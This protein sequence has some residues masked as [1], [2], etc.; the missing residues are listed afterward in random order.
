MH[1]G[2]FAGI[3]AVEDQVSEASTYSASRGL[4][5]NAV[6]CC[7]RI[8]APRESSA[9]RAAGR[10]ECSQERKSRHTRALYAGHEAQREQCADFHAGKRRIAA[11]GA[12]TTFLA[13]AGTDQD[14]AQHGAANQRG[15]A[16]PRKTTSL[17]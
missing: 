12:R 1:S 3:R 5:A 6:A 14:H 9:D 10:A 16:K 2:G 13:V 11:S 8:F 17:A 4:G 7:G 15:N